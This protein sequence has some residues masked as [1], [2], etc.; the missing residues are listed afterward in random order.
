MP[1][2]NFPY[3]DLHNLNLDWLVRQVKAN[4]ELLKQTDF[5]QLLS[6]ALQQ[7]I[8]DGTMEELIDQQV[9]TDI[10]ER[11]NNIAGN[12][13]DLTADSIMLERR[14]A[15]A[16]VAMLGR[17]AADTADP[18]RGYSLCVVIYNDNACVVYDTGNDNAEYL[19]TYLRGHGVA[20]IDAMI[21]SHYHSDHVTLAG[22][23]AI[24]AS[25]IPVSVWYLPHG[26]IDWSRY[27]HR[28]RQRGDVYQ[29]GYHRRRRRLYPA[30]L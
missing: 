16:T 20:K 2:N 29:G 7:A 4:T 15:T 5:R 17:P 18:D 19:L 10:T 28:I 11:L 25:G 24:L 6:E 1:Y 8:D 14:T 12:V 13:T 21:I 9:L 22:V 27:T 3:T 30:Q 26:G 23:N